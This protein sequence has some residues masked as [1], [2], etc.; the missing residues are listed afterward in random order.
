MKKIAATLALTAFVAVA[1]QPALAKDDK[2]AGNAAQAQAKVEKIDPARLE[3]ARKLIRTTT[4]DRLIDQILKMA[5]SQVGMV[6]V[7]MKPEKKKE[8]LEILDRVGKEMSTPE[9]KKDLMDRIA[10]IYARHF[11]TDEMNRLIAFYETP[12]GRKFIR[13][14]PE[15]MMESQK[16]GM[17][18]GRSVAQELFKRAKE[19]AKKKGIDL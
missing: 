12:V 9:R 16:A 11:T 18:W 17:E 14:M 7:R 2:A 4:S 19:E 8:L 3:A 5:I 6:M 15:I 13:K 10:H 1:A